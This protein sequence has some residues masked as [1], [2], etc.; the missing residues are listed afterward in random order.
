MKK[1]PER[2][3]STRDPSARSLR[4]FPKVD[5]EHACVTRNPFAERVASEGI[6]IVAEPS[7]ASLEQIPEASADSLRR[8][9]RNPN[10]AAR[11]SK[12]CP[13]SVIGL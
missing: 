4:E 2:R 5:F 7:A 10:R 12:R 9:R 1:R 8:G 11:V 6:A 3:R 13:M